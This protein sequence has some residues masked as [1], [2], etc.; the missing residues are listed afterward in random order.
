MVCLLLFHF[1]QV[2][3]FSDENIREE[4]ESIT[5]NA[6][7]RAESAF[8]MQMEQTLSAI[9]KEIIPMKEV[10]LFRFWSVK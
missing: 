5:L 8:I 4:N 10:I 2:F 6:A 3:L 9:K 7:L 1:I